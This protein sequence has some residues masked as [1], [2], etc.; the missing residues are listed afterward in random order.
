MILSLAPTQHGIGHICSG[1][2]TEIS[3][4]RKV[5]SEGLVI[6]LIRK[7]DNNEEKL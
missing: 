5:K 2:N 3:K 7:R 1:V 4:F 6:V